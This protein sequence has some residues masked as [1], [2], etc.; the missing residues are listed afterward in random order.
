MDE[1]L[2]PGLSQ[3]GATKAEDFAVFECLLL[4][5]RI[6]CI[7]SAAKAWKPLEVRNAHGRFGLAT[8]IGSLMCVSR[9]GRDRA[10]SGLR[11]DCGDF[12]LA[13]ELT[14]ARRC[15]SVRLKREVENGDIQ[16]MPDEMANGSL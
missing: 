1:Q 8:V 13:P 10:G 12:C 16:S 2:A 11:K 6:L 5:P 14:V 7:A 4:H 3:C 15:N 9:K